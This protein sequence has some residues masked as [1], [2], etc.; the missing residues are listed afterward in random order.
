VTRGEDKTGRA[1]VAL[2]YISNITGLTMVGL[3]AS[4]TD[5]ADFA[6]ALEDQGS[7]DPIGVEY[8]NNTTYWIFEWDEYDR[9]RI[10]AA[11]REQEQ[12]EHPEGPPPRTVYDPFYGNP[13]QVFAPTPGW[14]GTRVPG[15]RGS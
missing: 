9:A 1:A 13:I 14:V 7:G 11:Q 2:W 15:P 3:F 6:V 8:P 5:A 10:R 12:E 4:E